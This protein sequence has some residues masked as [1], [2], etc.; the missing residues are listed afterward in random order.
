M[1]CAP[2]AHDETTEAKVFAQQ[3]LQYVWILTCMR[4][5]NLLVGAHH[6]TCTC[7]DGS[8]EH[9]HVDLVLRTLSDIH[10]H[11]HPV[12]LLIIVEPMLDCHDDALLER[13][14][15][16]GH[17][18]LAA[19]EGVLSGES[20]EG[21]ATQRVAPDL[22]V[23]PQHHIGTLG[24]EFVGDRRRVGPRHLR[25][26]ARGHRE[27][28]W[29]LCGR[30]CQLLLI[31]IISLWAVVQHQRH[32][33]LVAEVIVGVDVSRVAMA[34][35]GPRVVLP[36]QKGHLVIKLQRLQQLASSLFGMFPSDMNIAID[37]EWVLL[38]ALFLGAGLPRMVVAWRARPPCGAPP[39]FALKF[40]LAIRI[41]RWFA[42]CPVIVLLVALRA[43]RG[44]AP[45]LHAITLRPAIRD[46]ALGLKTSCVRD[47]TAEGELR[48]GSVT[49]ST[50][51]GP[52]SRQGVATP[53][54]PIELV[55]GRWVAT[56]HASRP[57]LVFLIARLRTVTTCLRCAA[58]FAARSTL[59]ALRKNRDH[60]VACA[61]A[62][63]LVTRRPVDAE[64]QRCC[65]RNGRR[66]EQRCRY[67]DSP[68][69]TAVR[70][71]NALRS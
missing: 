48:A 62:A 59:A 35:I 39:T 53:R 68:L 11:G 7:L 4:A 1:R 58:I 54:L 24:G 2:I 30:A 52:A 50:T 55:G 64:R 20:L 19:E 44:A 43:R 61:V 33:A 36:A 14:L 31:V 28:R 9:G 38:G 37:K 26:E 60:V 29:E 41:A 56:R 6:S 47:I 40:C 17:H 13:L 32:C 45:S 49:G 51:A 57:E 63:R 46:R 22:D 3:L 5:S 71:R 12:I 42:T 23:W 21:A 65:H 27:Q 18:Q 34:V 10:V 16:E 8:L 25:V 70:R 69:P 66:R 15:H 67:A